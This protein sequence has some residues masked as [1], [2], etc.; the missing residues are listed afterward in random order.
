MNTLVC[1]YSAMFFNFKIPAFWHPFPAKKIQHLIPSTSS[2]GGHTVDNIY[3]LTL[4][5]LPLIN[6]Q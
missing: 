4:S 1:T 3:F 5:A 6:I 2:T